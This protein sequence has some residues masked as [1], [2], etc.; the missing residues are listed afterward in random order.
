M[1]RTDTVFRPVI[2][3]IIPRGK[4]DVT[5]TFGFG[6][7]GRLNVAEGKLTGLQGEDNGRLFGVNCVEAVFG[8]GTDGRIGHV[9]VRTLAALPGQ[10]NC[11]VMAFCK[12]FSFSFEVGD[13]GSLVVSFKRGDNLL[14]VSEMRFPF[15]NFSAVGAGALRGLSVVLLVVFR[16]LLVSEFGLGRRAVVV[17]RVIVVLRVVFVHDGDDAADG[18]HHG[19]HISTYLCR[20]R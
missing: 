12:P 1:V 10:G 19:T 16:R 9:V 11:G 4:R 3:I 17:L 6:F 8:D 13:E 2:V 5:T 7:L 15:R 18:N 20:E 14:G